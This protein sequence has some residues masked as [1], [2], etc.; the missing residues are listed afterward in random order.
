[1]DDPVQPSRRRGPLQPVVSSEGDILALALEIAVRNGDP[2][3]EL[4][5]HTIGSREAATKTTGSW[6]HSEEP[7]YLVAMRGSFTARR[8]APPGL[9]RHGVE[10]E[11]VSFP[12]QV[13]VVEIN[14]GRVT[15]SGGDFNYPDLASVGPVIT[16]CRGSGPVKAQC[17]RRVLLRVHRHRVAARAK[18]IRARREPVQLRYRGGV[19]IG[20]PGRVRFHDRSGGLSDFIWQALADSGWVGHHTSERPRRASI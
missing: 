1:M 19:T 16:D 4:I 7:S 11:M 9:R 8:A 10:D 13:L 15:D 14:S 18:R 5:Q 6:V 12:V 3:P 20:S 17:W 2:S